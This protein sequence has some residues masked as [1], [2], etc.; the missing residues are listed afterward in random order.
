MD[1]NRQAFEA[2]ISASPYERS[3]KRLH[4]DSSWPNQ[5]ADY[6]VQLAWEA[7]QKSREQAAQSGG[8]T[9]T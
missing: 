8:E 2:W 4:D 9:G 7:W 5:Y 3:T 6:H 1:E